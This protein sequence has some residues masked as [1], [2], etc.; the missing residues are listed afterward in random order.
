M[1]GQEVLLETPVN[2]LDFLQSNDSKQ[3]HA[4]EGFEFKW[5]S[6]ANKWK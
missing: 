5:R 2:C 3:A 6:K 4:G 1:G